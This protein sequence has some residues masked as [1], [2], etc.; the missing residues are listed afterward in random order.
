MATTHLLEAPPL[1][2]AERRRRD[3]RERVLLSEDD[4]GW[5]ALSDAEQELRLG[6]AEALLE[7]GARPINLNDFD[8]Q[9]DLTLR[10]A[11]RELRSKLRALLPSGER[12]RRM[13]DAEQEQA[14]AEADGLNADLAL[15][16]A[17]LD[18]RAAEDDQVAQAAPTPYV[19]KPGGSARGMVPAFCADDDDLSRFIVG[20][21]PASASGTPTNAPVQRP[22]RPR[23]RS[24]PSSAMAS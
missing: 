13:S 8:G 6:V 17:E 5:R 11:A 9:D 4:D 15:V 7:P 19:V 14:L 12:W 22:C 24:A 3:D 16:G 10:A 23:R 20:G 1:A 21:I 18:R 2:E